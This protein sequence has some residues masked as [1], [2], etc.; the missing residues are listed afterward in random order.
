MTSGCIISPDIQQQPQEPLYPPVVLTDTLEPPDSAAVIELDS[1]CSPALFSVGVIRDLNTRD[2]LY[3]RW[4]EDWN[5]EIDSDRWVTVFIYPVPG[6]TDRPGISTYLPLEG[7]ETGSVHS[8]RFFVADRPPLNGGNGMQLP[9]GSDGQ[10]DF[11]QWT[12]K[13]VTAGSGVCAS[14]QV[15]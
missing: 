10:Y 13:L 4:L 14:E 9:E 12:F 3:A 15:P 5:E 11:V 2:I 1:S 8:L 6:Q 7:Y